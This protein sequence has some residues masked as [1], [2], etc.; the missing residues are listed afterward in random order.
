MPLAPQRSIYS[1][2]KAAVNSLSANARMDLER[3]TR[4][5]T[6]NS[7]ARQQLDT[8][9]STVSQFEAQVRLDQALIDNAKAVLEYT[10]IT[11]PIDG[12]PR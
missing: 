11:A 9:K 5:M 2:A 3:Y 4:L 1:A 10:N 7:V 12:M 6:T 8:Q